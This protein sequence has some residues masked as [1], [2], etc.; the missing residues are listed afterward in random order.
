M[1]RYG[2]FKSKMMSGRGNLLLS[3]SLPHLLPVF[4]SKFDIVIQY[5]KYHLG[6]EK[7]TL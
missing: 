2:F 1:D 7:H 5:I 3:H 6:L 4:L